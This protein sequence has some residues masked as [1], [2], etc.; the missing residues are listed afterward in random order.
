[1]SAR[2]TYAHTRLPVCL[3]VR[4]PLHAAIQAPEGPALATQIGLCL[5]PERDVLMQ[6]S[7]VVAGLEWVGLNHKLPAVVTMS[8]G[9]QVGHRPQSESSLGSCSRHK[10]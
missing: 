5:L 6:V 3:D 8:L 4:V 2:E 10:G 1:M 9:V 7:D